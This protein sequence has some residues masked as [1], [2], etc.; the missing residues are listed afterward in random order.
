MLRI[1]V[2]S[3]FEFLIHKTKLLLFVDI[4]PKS[5]S[6]V[7]EQKHFEIRKG[8]GPLIVYGI[9]IQIMSISIV[10]LF[11]FCWDIKEVRQSGC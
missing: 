11:S 2:S 3:N 5:W 4:H 7:W 6:L 1:S 8:S 10:L 9:A